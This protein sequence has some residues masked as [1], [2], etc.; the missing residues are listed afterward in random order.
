[1]RQCEHLFNRTSVIPIRLLEEKYD[2]HFHEQ[3][4]ADCQREHQDTHFTTHQICLDRKKESYCKGPSDDDGVCKKSQWLI[5]A[6]KMCR[7]L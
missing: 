4:A 2:S 5:D 1:M 7:Q 3:L 6:H